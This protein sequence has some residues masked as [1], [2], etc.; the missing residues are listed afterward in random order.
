MDRQEDRSRLDGP[1]PSLTSQGEQQTRC[2]IIAPGDLGHAGPKFERL[3][4]E[5]GLVVRRPAP[6]TFDPENFRPHLPLTLK[7]DLRSD[8]A[9]PKLIRKA[10]LAGRVRFGN[11]KLKYNATEGRIK[12]L[13]KLIG[14]ADEA[15]PA[16]HPSMADR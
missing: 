9:P 7:P 11:D 1:C 14:E 6:P 15:P 13:E 5:P 4:Y 2:Q 16:I 8:G 12:E 3:R 10:V